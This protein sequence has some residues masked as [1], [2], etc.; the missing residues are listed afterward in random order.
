MNM[1]G[2]TGLFCDMMIHDFD[3]GAVPFSRRD[4]VVS[5]GARDRQ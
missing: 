3:Y 1:S 5:A 2:V 4:C